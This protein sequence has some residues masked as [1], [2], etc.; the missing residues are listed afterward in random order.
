MKKKE[1]E[2][3]EEDEEYEE[4]DEEEDKEEPA[5]KTKKTIESTN[6]YSQKIPEVLSVIDPKSKK[7]M[8]QSLTEE[9]LRLQLLIIAAQK[10]TEAAKNT[11]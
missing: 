1:T 2:E 5:K 3:L 10:A 4:D 8:A 9:D 7:I 11:E 6:W